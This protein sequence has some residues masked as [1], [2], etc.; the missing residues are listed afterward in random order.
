MRIDR[1]AP[2]SLRSCVATIMFDLRRRRY[3]RIIVLIFILMNAVDV[4]TI[5][6]IP[7]TAVA[8]GEHNLFVRIC[9]LSIGVPIAMIISK[10]VGTALIFTSSIIGGR[11]WLD[12]G[13][14]L[15]VGLLVGATVAAVGTAMNITNGLM[16]SSVMHP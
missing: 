6:M 14:I 10:T 11:I 7:P 13:K 15:G 5:S 12:M 2:Q 3:L 4:L 9:A 8:R 16:N 1:F